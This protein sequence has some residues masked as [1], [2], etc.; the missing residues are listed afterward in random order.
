[1]KLTIE[2]KI[3]ELLDNEGSREIVEKHLPGLSTHPMIGMARGMTLNQIM[4][5]S[6]GQVTPEVIE[7]ISE[8]LEN[9]A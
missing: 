4:P 6:D 2:S 5:F 3:S 8:D 7:A 1:M 9:L